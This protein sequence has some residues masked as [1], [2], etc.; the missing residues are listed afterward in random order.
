MAISRKFEIFV[1]KVHCSTSAEI[2]K[3]LFPFI[4]NCF[5]ADCVPRHIDD[6]FILGKDREKETISKQI[7][8]GVR[9][10]YVAVTVLC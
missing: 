8:Y 7:V 1:E 5:T 3:Q 2:E 4:R 10:M 9:E 6:P